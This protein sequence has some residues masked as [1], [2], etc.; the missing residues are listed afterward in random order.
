MLGTRQESYYAQ[1]SV[2]YSDR[3]FWTL[4]GDYVPTATSLQPAGRRINSDSDDVRIN[5]KVGFTPNDTDEYTVNFTRQQGSK[6]GILNVYTNPPVPANSYWRWPEWNIQSITGLSYTQLGAAYLKLKLYYNEYTNTLKAYDDITFTTQSANGRFTSP[7]SDDAKGISLELGGDMGRNALKGAMHV[8]VDTHDE[9]NINRPTNATAITTEPV[10]HQAQRTWSFALEDTF[11]VSPVL[12][13]VAGVS[14]DDYTVSASEDYNTTAGVFSYPKGGANTFN[15][16]GA[17]IWN[18]S[19]TGQLHA[20][21]SDRARFPIFFE[22][23]STRFGT[24]VPNPYL[25]PERAINYEVGVKEMFGATRVEGAVFYSDVRDLIQTVQV[26]AGAMP[27]TQAQN[28]GN[29]E[30]YGFEISADTALSSQFT[31]GG[32]YSYIYRKVTDALQPRLRL[33]GVP[34]NKAF[35]YLTWRPDA[36]FSVTPSIEIASDRWSDRTTSPAQAFPYIKVGAYTLV[37]LQAEY[38][39]TQNFSFTAGA[40]N[41]TDDNYELSW[42]L[43]QSGRTYYFRVRASF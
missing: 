37:N 7:Y 13:L 10:Q 17:A 41:I 34:K 35:A 38:K 23:Y 20:T 39:I 6:G 29:G 26:T 32:N 42:G 16:Q 40:K 11:H 27:Q 24:A 14:Y 4:S 19:D 3:N 2:S 18:Y 22:L 8:R 15:F 25:G 33:T 12:D 31:L 43:P 36:Q 1:A 9:Y 28:V 5:A 21:V 30:F